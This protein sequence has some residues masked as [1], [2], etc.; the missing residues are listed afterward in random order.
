MA[1]TVSILSYANTFGDWVT[2]TNALVKENNDIAANN[3]I[4][5]T[6][7]LFL[8]DPTLGLQ[9][10]NNAIIAGTLQVQGTGSS[11]YVQNNLRV[12][13][14]VYFT[15]TALSLVAS[16]QANVGGLLFARGSGTGLYVSNNATVAG[17][18]TVGGL[19]TVGGTLTIGGA[20]EVDNTLLVT[21][22]TT[23]SN[24]LIVTGNTS[25]AGNVQVS[26]YL[27]VTNDISGYNTKIANDANTNTLIVRSSASV[28]GTTYT[29]KLQAN[30]SANTRTLS[31]TGYTLTDTL[32]A[33]TSANTGTLSV[34]GKTSTDTLQA[35]TSANTVTLSVVGTGYLNVVQANTKVNTTTLSVTNTGY[36]DVVQANTKVNTATV[37][38][39]GTTYTNTLQANTNINTITASV[40]GTGFVNALQ[41]NTSTNTALAFVTNRTY[42]NFLTANSSSNLLGDVVIGNPTGTSANLTVTGSFVINGATLFDT[43]RIV[44]KAVTGQTIGSGYDYLVINRGEA[45]NP[46]NANAQIRWNES[47]AYWDLRD[48]NNPTSYS[49]ILTANL[50]NDSVTSTSSSTLASSKSANTLNNSIISVNSALVTAN[51]SMKSYVDANVSSLQSQ[52]SSN[53]SS[54]QSQISSNVAFIGGVDATQNTNISNNLIYAQAAFSK[55][56]TGGTFSGDVTV[57]GNL[58]VNGTTTTVNT[59]TVTTKDSLIK[60]ADGNQADSLDVG[61]YGQYNS[62]GVKY[63]GLFRKAADKFY[64]VKDVT[65]DPTGNTVTFTSANRAV[66]DASLTGGTVSGLAS[67]ISIADGGTGN[68]SYTTGAR[69]IYDGTKF[70]SLANS[71]YTLT[72]SLATNNTLTSLTI[73]AYG[74]VTA[75]TGSA[76]A[77]TSSQ[78][79]GLA[80]SATTDTTNASNITSGTLPNARLSSVPNSA[81][82]NYTISGVALGGT[83]NTLTMNTS[84]TGLS[85]STTYNGSGAATFTVASNATNL[86]TGS[87]IVAR[88]ASGNFN[89]GTI[90]ATLSGNASTATLASKASTLSQSGGNGTAMTFNWSGQSGQPTWLWGGSDGVN[91][92]VYNPSNFSVNYATTAG[93]ATNISAYT[94]NQSVGTGNDVQHNSLGVG[95]GPTG[96]SGEIV[97]TNNITAYYSDMRLKNKLG[98]IDNALAKVMTL[99]GFYYEA[100]EI[101]QSLGYDVKKEVGVSAQEVQAIMPEVVAP[102]PIDNQYLTVRYEKLVPLLIEAI[103][104]LKA[105]ID[106][107]KATK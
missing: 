18:L 60:L 62:S 5:P 39:T 59:S 56:N 22:T 88:D 106:E 101:A 58:V 46:A 82:A 64:L 24:N 23:I 40:S 81:L 42:T 32:Q 17:T 69:L 72:G 41:A 77:I 50:I 73:D 78:V 31:V 47:A 26:N 57:T 66:V 14:Q 92:Y 49:K 95:T 1:N 98:N 33:N 97:A 4:K 37:S 9:I 28:V 104:E 83:L 19:E 55:A 10:A 102:A 68:A 38:V 71:T 90:S 99:S 51:A 87:T 6:G 3:Y 61:F 63:A 8:N 34:T 94:I 12:D 105:E 103:K 52:I 89:A 20:T 11:A 29:D 30:T 67:V 35:N 36:L 43:D 79:S 75:A 25:V 93:S 7:T 91:M 70:V 48:V 86:N 96:T 45:S 21:G 15:N 80:A 107:L 2:T 53:V 76:I 100:N 74:R 44:L 16:G 85:G 27:A 65:T 13:Q 54:L 84:G